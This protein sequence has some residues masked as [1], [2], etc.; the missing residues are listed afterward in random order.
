MRGGISVLYIE[1]LVSA[2]H[3]SADRCPRSAAILAAGCAGILT[4]WA[5]TPRDRPAESRRS[6]LLRVVLGPLEVQR[7][8]RL[9]SDHPAIVRNCR[10]VKDAAG[11]QFDE[12]AVGIRRGGLT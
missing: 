7:D 4:A 10:N 5:L 9:I 8:V 6:R 12:G 1:Y 2:L 3:V 11:S